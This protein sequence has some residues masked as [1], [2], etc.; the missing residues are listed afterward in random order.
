MRQFNFL[1][2]VSLAEASI[3]NHSPSFV[4]LNLRPKPISSYLQFCDGLVSFTYIIAIVQ[5]LMQVMLIASDYLKLFFIFCKK[6][7]ILAS[8]STDPQKSVPCITAIGYN[9]AR[10]WQN[11]IILDIDPTTHLPPTPCPC[12]LS[13][14]YICLFICL[15]WGVKAVVR[16]LC[17]GNLCTYFILFFSLLCIC[18]GFCCWW[19]LSIQSWEGL[20]RTSC[21]GVCCGT[22]DCKC[23][24]LNNYNLLT[25][26]II[27]INKNYTGS[28]F[29]FSFT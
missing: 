28:L 6:N 21:P 2:Y 27:N 20:V 23:C 18:R 3:S 29:T 14:F 7:C 9:G 15:F 24:V 17:K 5:S 26:D 8:I 12:H 1:K 10:V 19:N 25:T 16:Y 11:G 13:L 22:L 4:K